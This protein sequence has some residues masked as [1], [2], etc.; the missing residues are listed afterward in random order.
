MLDKDTPKPSFAK[1]YDIVNHRLSIKNRELILEM[2][3]NNILNKISLLKSST[4][5]NKWNNLNDEVLTM[6]NIFKGDTM[7]K[8]SVG[9]DDSGVF[10]PK[11]SMKKFTDPIFQKLP[12]NK[13]V[14]YDRDLMV[15][16][17][18]YGMVLQLQYRG[19]D[20][21]FVQGRSRIIVPCC[22]GTSMK[23]KPLLRAYH[24]MGF[25]LSNNKNIEKIWRMFRTDRI[26]SM[27]FVG[28][29]YRLAPEGYNQNDKGMRGG[30]IKSIDFNEVQ[31]NQKKLVDSGAIQN[32]KEVVINE[33]NKVG[34]V[35]VQNT[36]SVLDLM[37]PFDNPNIDEKNKSILRMTFLKNTS[38][39]KVICILGAISTKGTIVKLTSK[40]SNIGTYRVMRSSMGDG[41]G[42]PHLR[43]LEGFN[44]FDVYVFIRK[45][46]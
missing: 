15:M 18:E 36:N 32:K 23:G 10:V 2:N 44:R 21:S 5:Y 33:K 12:P 42:L 24:L 29:F 7:I 1:M 9:N 38:N 27:K 39:N 4:K 43:Y 13:E 6:S 8:E 3:K 14:K 19:E 16:A 30:I 37:K 40:G 17:M 46:S 41:L 34:V 28:S 35:E 31:N 22:L 25:S 45:V 20:D 11:F 26:L